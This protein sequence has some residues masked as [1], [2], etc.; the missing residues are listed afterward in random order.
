MLAVYFIGMGACSVAAGFAETPA[1]LWWALSGIGLFAA[2]YHPVGIPLVIRN[3]GKNQGA[4]LAVNGVF[5]SFGAALAGVVSGYLAQRGG[6]FLAF[7]LPGIVV[8]ATGVVMTLGLSR[9]AHA[10]PRAAPSSKPSAQG[11]AR[12]PLLVLLFCLTAAGLIYHATQTV[13][14]KVLSVRMPGNP[15]LTAVGWYVALIYA[16]GGLFQFIGGA[17]ADRCNL[18]AVYLW[19]FVAHAVLLLIAAQAD[20]ALLILALCAAVA[21]GAGALPAENMLLARYTPS[22]HYGLVFGLKFVLFFCTGP[23][24][25]LLV[26]AVARIT[27]QFV[28]VFF[29]MGMVGRAHL[30]GR[31]GVAA[32][33]AG[34]SAGDVMFQL[35]NRVLLFGNHRLDQIADGNH[36][37]NPPVLDHRQMPKAFFGHQRHAFIDAQIAS[38]R[39]HLGGHNVADAR[40]VGGTVSQNHLARIIAL[41]QDADQLLAIH[42]RQ[43]PDALFRH[44]P[45]RIQHR[46]LRRHPPHHPASLAQNITNRR[47]DA[48]PG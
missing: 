46:L 42:H 18:K 47:H 32:Q 15:P 11:T 17:L 40:G 30:R 43:R 2:I 8:A 29:A 31:L 6:S 5:G 21:L 9:R 41:A 1:K 12:A 39:R 48:P 37:N 34:R 36:A 38:R 19:Q 24:G 44:Q 4:A 13:A 28:G 27:G 23:V 45:N 33:H 10:A 7:V 26:A 22:R 3:S 35:V 14:P 16:V 20:G 25:V